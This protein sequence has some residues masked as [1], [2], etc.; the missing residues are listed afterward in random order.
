MANVVSFVVCG[1]GSGVPTMKHSGVGAPLGHADFVETQL[2]QRLDD[3]QLLLNRILEVPAAWAGWKT[4][5]EVHSSVVTRFRGGDG[6]RSLTLPKS[7][8]DRLDTP[9]MDSGFCVWGLGSGLYISGRF[10]TKTVKK[11]ANIAT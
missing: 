10:R 1:T 2:R 11:K 6:V 5:L 3:H 9:S 4:V 7:Y 8:H